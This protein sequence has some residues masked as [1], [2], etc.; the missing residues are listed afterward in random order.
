[1]KIDFKTGKVSYPERDA[2]R[3]ALIKSLEELKIK[4]T[5]GVDPVVQ[6]T[7][8][9]GL[10]HGRLK[11]LFYCFLLVGDGFIGLISIGQ[12]QSIIAQKFLLSDY[13]MEGYDDRQ[14]R[15]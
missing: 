1:M 15:R 6:K 14:N 7:R 8:H 12:T 9:C 2:E 10:K 4:N 5:P 13:V 11:F 3:E